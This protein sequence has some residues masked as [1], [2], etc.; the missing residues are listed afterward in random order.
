MY[1]VAC[2]I[3]GLY[4]GISFVSGGLLIDPRLLVALVPA[5]ALG[6]ALSSRNSGE[7][8]ARWQQVML[9]AGSL[10]LS[11]ALTFS[12]G[13][14]LASSG[15]V[16]FGYRENAKP[17]PPTEQPAARISEPRVDGTT[18]AER[19]VSTNAMPP[20][21]VACIASVFI[22]NLS[23]GL[24]LGRRGS[25]W[26]VEMGPG[27]L[28]LL[29]FGVGVAFLV[30]YAQDNYGYHATAEQI[31]FSFLFVAIGYVCGRKLRRRN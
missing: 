30:W 23:F 11:F 24:Y 25:K 4:A 29:L 21:V 5:V 20:V 12:I 2:L 8:R 26:N 9:R 18:G 13:Y 28:L 7:Q 15:L 14:G 16:T 22:M 17:A 3:G 27:G 31:E 19:S 6:M 1:H 10:S